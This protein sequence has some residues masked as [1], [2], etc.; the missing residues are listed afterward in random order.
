MNFSFMKALL[1]DILKTLLLIFLFLILPVKNILTINLL[2]LC[3]VVVF[4]LRTEILTRINPIPKEWFV[5]CLKTLIITNLFIALWMIAGYLGLIGFILLSLAVGAYRIYKGRA[6]FDSFTTWAADKLWGRTNKD[7]EY[8]GGV[9]IE[10]TKG[11]RTE[12]EEDTRKSVIDRKGK[13]RK[14]EP[15]KW[16][17][18]KSKSFTGEQQDCFKTQELLP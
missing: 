14:S 16:P 1:P 15:I 17:T 4:K 8:K 18:I 5:V 7:F 10:G 9:N 6:L 11:I 13:G 2:T 12:D 3:W